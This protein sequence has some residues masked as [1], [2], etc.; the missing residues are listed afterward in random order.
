M[1]NE[2]LNNIIVIAGI[3]LL[4][5][6][7]LV[8]TVKGE[9]DLTG[10][11][12]AGLG[13]ASLV[14]YSIVNFERVKGLFTNRATRY[15]FNAA[16]YSILVIGAIIL[17]QTIFTIHTKEFDLTKAKRHTLSEQTNM[18][19]KNLKTDVEAYYFY[20]VRARN[21]QIEDILK[22]YGKVSPKFKF[23]AV[24]A[25]R[26]PSMAMKYKVDRYGVVVLARPDN[27]SQERVDILTE[28]GVTNGLIRITRDGK[29]KI[30]FLTGHGEPSVSGPANDKSGYAT[31]KSELES[32]NYEV[33]EVELFSSPGV[34]ADCS[35]LVS[36]GSKADLF[37]N[38][39]AAINRYLRGNGRVVLMLNP[40]V[41]TPKLSALLLSRGV[42]LHNDIVVDKMGRM[43]GGDPLMPIISQYEDH[44]ITKSFR[45]A[46]FMPNLRTVELKGG[47]RGV[48]LKALASTNPGSWGE[49]NLASIRQ[50]QVAQDAGDL[51][52]PLTAAA[53]VDID[54]SVYTDPSGVTGTGKTSIVIFGS[55]DFANNTYIG[56]SGNRDFIL[57]AFNFLAGEGD[58]IAIKPKDNMF[59]PL[60]MSKIN[61]RLLFLVP[62]IFLP[63]LI[64]GIGTL[65]YIRR[66]SS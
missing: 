15:G 21:T 43:F 32:Y 33:S 2:K 51:T 5:I 27:K 22:N 39:A 65:V 55:S 49:T 47:V 1:K 35:I 16:V 6:A 48:E 44:D 19:L 26:S 63:L 46:S 13:A 18:V 17:A 57:N 59:E 30:Y 25:D 54:N 62:T 3:A 37:D 24:D 34:P 31:L 14:L 52:A 60:F 38:E 12:M 58:T 4:V 7:A 45:T 11:I 41:N 23:T 42:V 10:Y 20:S 9:F 53:V 56:T 50:G 66:K 40:L 36:A 64:I 29:K 61:G 8:A 28:E